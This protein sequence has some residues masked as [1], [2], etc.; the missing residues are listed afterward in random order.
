MTNCS[1][2]IVFSASRRSPSVVLFMVDIMR[3]TD[4]AGID[5]HQSLLPGLG[6][7]PHGPRLRM[8]QRKAK[9]LTWDEARQI[10]ANYCSAG[11][12]SGST[13]GGGRPTSSTRSQPPFSASPRSAWMRRRSCSACRTILVSNAGR[14]TPEMGPPTGR[15]FGQLMRTLNLVQQQAENPRKRILF[16]VKGQRRVAYWSIDTPIDAYALPDA[17][18]FSIDCA[19]R[20]AT[21]RT[22]LNPFTADEIKLLLRSGYAVKDPSGP[23]LG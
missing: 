22:R 11:R 6:R 14:N 23:I 18:A 3:P 2:G 9:V 1:R 20:A 12:S 15:W 21:M 5:E 10:A 7:A 8:Y 17:L 13:V 19:A 4:Q 16:G